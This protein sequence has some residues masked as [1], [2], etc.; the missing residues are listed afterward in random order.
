LCFSAAEVKSEG[1]LP[2]MDT[3]ADPLLS[4][5][6]NLYVDISVVY[7]EDWHTGIQRV[8]RAML[9]SLPAE[10]P[11]GRRLVPVFAD[12]VDGSW[13]YKD[14]SD[15]LAIT[16]NKHFSPVGDSALKIVNPLAGDVFLGL[17]LA[18]S[19][20]V[21]AGRQNFYARLRENWVKVYFVVYDLLP[22]TRPAYFSPEDADGHRQWLEAV[23]QGNG[24]LCISRSVAAAVKRWLL[25][26]ERFFRPDFTVDWFHLGA[27]LE[28]SRPSAGMTENARTVLGQMDQR[29]SFL[30]VGTLEPRKGCAQVLGAF[31][32]LWS[33][34]LDVNLVFAGSRGWGVDALVERIQAHP[35][36]DRRLF[37]LQAVSDEC[38]EK[39]YEA[40][41][42]LIAASAD[43]GFGLPLIEAARHKL[44]VIARDIPVFR[45]VAGE[46]AFYFPDEKDPDALA[47][48]IGQ[49]L[50]LFASGKHPLPDDMPW[51]TW[52]QSAV[53]LVDRLFH[54]NADRGQF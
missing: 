26:N 10:L 33:Q 37:W 14:A 51:L 28:N 44:P 7:R 38:L 32:R 19:Y 45:E 1:I 43:E 23:T 42:C 22:L 25:E 13:V 54:G 8:V 30:V 21:Q 11:R 48:A 4:P 53:Q 17:D 29:P 40:A 16:S 36:C 20:V 41:T 6:Y 15:Y 24:V 49:W 3:T 39:L 12:C 35:E 50:D 46:R 9:A 34:G 2:E 5:E 47:Q 52:Q 27:D 31:E 18:G